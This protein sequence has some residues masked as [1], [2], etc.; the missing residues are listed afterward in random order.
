MRE[1]WLK[2]WIDEA[3]NVLCEGFNVTQDE[4]KTMVRLVFHEG[5]YN[6]HVEKFIRAA[7]RESLTRYKE[8]SREEVQEL[9]YKVLLVG[10][11]KVTLK[12]FEEYSEYRLKD[13]RGA[14]MLKKKLPKPSPEPC[15]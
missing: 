14:A 5:A 1:Q 8:M 3:L 2:W 12:L 11:R 15:L 7:V 9:F 13:I 10:L 6:Y 4:L